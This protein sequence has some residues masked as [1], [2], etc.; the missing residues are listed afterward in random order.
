LEKVRRASNNEGLSETDFFNFMNTSI[1]RNNNKTPLA[2]PRIQDSEKTPLLNKKSNILPITQVPSPVKSEKQPPPFLGLKHSDDE[3]SE[4]ITKAL[5]S[6]PKISVFGN[7]P[8]RCNSRPTTALVYLLNAALSEINTK[9]DT[10]IHHIN[11]TIIPKKALHEPEPKEVEPTQ[12]ELECLLPDESKKNYGTFESSSN[13]AITHQKVTAHDYSA[14][15]NFLLERALESKNDLE[16]AKYNKRADETMCC[17][18]ACRNY[19]NSA[20]EYVRSHENNFYERAHLYQKIAQTYNHAA[21]EF[22]KVTQL[23]QPDAQ[24]GPLLL[25]T[26]QG[27]DQINTE[28]NLSQFSFEQEGSMQDYYTLIT[29]PHIVGGSNIST[30]QQQKE[31]IERAQASIKRA[32]EDLNAM[33]FLVH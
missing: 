22:K 32:N 15:I 24:T 21:S 6:F 13:M 20:K 33:R 10:P 14:I 9:E 8:S 30:I 4:V 2:D 3:G 29:S 7:P 5:S 26:R 17:L 18:H 12:E 28:H 11:G 23:A 1:Q 27:Q 31:A 19:R 25:Y 16:N